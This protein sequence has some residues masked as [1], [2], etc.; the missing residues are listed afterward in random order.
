MYNKNRKSK[1]ASADVPKT[2]ILILLIADPIEG[3]MI[4][5]I[6]KYKKKLISAINPNKKKEENL[7]HP[8]QIWSTKYKIEKYFVMQFQFE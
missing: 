2:Q 8:Y 5:T 4:E 7:T 6:E 1:K 3:T